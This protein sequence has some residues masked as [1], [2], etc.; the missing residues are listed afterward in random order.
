MN[1]TCKYL[2]LLHLWHWTKSLGLE[3]PVPTHFY[4]F[5]K[6]SPTCNPPLPS[7]PNFLKPPLMTAFL[8]CWRSTMPN[9]VY[10]THIVWAW[11]RVLLLHNNRWYF[12]FLSRYHLSSLSGLNSRPDLLFSSHAALGN[13]MNQRR[14]EHSDNQSHDACT[15]HGATFVLTLWSKRVSEVTAVCFLSAVKAQIIRPR[16]HERPHTLPSSCKQCRFQG[17]DRCGKIFIYLKS[18]VAW[19]YKDFRILLSHAAFSVW[20]LQ[21]SFKL[22]FFC[23]SPQLNLQKMIRL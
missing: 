11:V 12:I 16:A 3:T 2:W 14:T 10:W 1:V 21:E 22:F 23:D 7:V 19:T 20:T 4:F 6:C 18:S 15:G 13:I 5:D 9:T 17:F 8:P